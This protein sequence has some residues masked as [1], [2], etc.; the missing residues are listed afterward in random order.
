MNNT[1]SRPILQLEA[2]LHKQQPDVI[3]HRL[4]IDEYY[5]FCWG[6][7]ANNP[8]ASISVSQISQLI[9]SYFPGAIAYASWPA[10]LKERFKNVID[11]SKAGRAG[12]ISPSHLMYGMILYPV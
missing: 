4:N 3:F 1:L 10:E 2:V 6:Y 12:R 7:D 8:A 5:I 11:L 9:C